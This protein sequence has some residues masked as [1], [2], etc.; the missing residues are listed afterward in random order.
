MP[1]WVSVIL[2]ILTMAY[3]TFFAEAVVLFL[4]VDLL[5]GVREEKFWGMFFISLSIAILLFLIIE[6][7]KKK[8][9]FYPSHSWYA[10]C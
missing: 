1:F 8:L 2:A 5:Y 10:N 6:L 3:F 4:L 7:S 9:K